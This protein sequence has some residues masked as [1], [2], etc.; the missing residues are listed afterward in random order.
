MVVVFDFDGVVNKSAYFSIKY[1][2]DYGITEQEISIFFEL[3]FDKCAK[4][5]VDIKTVLPPYLEKWK[6]KESLDAFL[7]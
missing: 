4:G 5:E 7:D 3:E 1:E 2:K 6:W